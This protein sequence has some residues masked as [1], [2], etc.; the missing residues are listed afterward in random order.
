MLTMIVYFVE[1]KFNGHGSV[2]TKSVTKLLFEGTQRDSLVE[3][4][5]A[6]RDPIIK[7]I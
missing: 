7:F 2:M 6:V 1:F 4:N 5:N 3:I